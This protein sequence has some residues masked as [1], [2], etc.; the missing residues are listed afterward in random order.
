MSEYT[1]RDVLTD[2]EADELAYA[3]LHIS[4][5]RAQL[6]A[7]SAK[8]RALYLRAKKRIGRAQK[9]VDTQVEHT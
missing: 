8:R 7:E 3:E 6:R 4:N 5:A 2:A 9:S 1:W